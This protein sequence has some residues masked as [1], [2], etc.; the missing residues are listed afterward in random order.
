MPKI[1]AILKVEFEANSSNQEV[2]DLA[3]DQVLLLQPACRVISK[4]VSEIDGRVV[5]S[6]EDLR[7]LNNNIWGDGGSPSNGVGGDTYRP[8]YSEHDRDKDKDRRRDRGSH[9]DSYRPGTPEHNLSNSRSLDSYRPA[10]FSSSDP[11]TLHPDGYKVVDLDISTPGPLGTRYDALVDSMIFTA[12][13][14]SSRPKKKKHRIQHY[15]PPPA[16]RRDRSASPRA[17]AG[18]RRS[19]RLR[20]ASNGEAVRSSPP[21]L[22]MGHGRKVSSDETHTS[23]LQERQTDE[24]D[25]RRRRRRRRSGGEVDPRLSPL[26]ILA[27][28]TVAKDLTGEKTKFEKQQDRKYNQEPPFIEPVEK[29][30]LLT[31]INLRTRPRHSRSP[32]PQEP[33]FQ[34]KSPKSQTALRQAAMG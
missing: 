5:S 15:S 25:E 2:I 33:A 28:R 10:N 27:P 1:Q 16:S 30:L 4:T 18:V 32:P 22:R 19:S 14:R 3:L 13:S 23:R 12:D 34:P 21:G 26:E 31:D 20:A 8:D 24:D 9:I 17:S 11:L 6:Q 7:H 29:A